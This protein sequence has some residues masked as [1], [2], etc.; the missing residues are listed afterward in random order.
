M[1]Q[2]IIRNN[3]FNTRFNKKLCCLQFILTDTNQSLWFSGQID[4]FITEIFCFFI[5]SFKYDLLETYISLFLLNF[6]VEKRIRM[7]EGFYYKIFHHQWMPIFIQ[8]L[9]DLLRI[10]VRLQKLADFVQSR[11]QLLEKPTPHYGRFCYFLFR[12]A[13]IRLKSLVKYWW[14]Q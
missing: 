12:N 8:N 2:P 10:H 11:K 6:P 7:L 14:N 5:F 13:T 1:L 4:S 9:V 3:D